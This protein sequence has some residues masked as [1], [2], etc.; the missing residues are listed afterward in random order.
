MCSG[1]IERLQRKP[2]NPIAAISATATG[3]NRPRPSTRFERVPGP[4]AATALNLRGR[5]VR[6]LDRDVLVEQQVHGLLGDQL[7]GEE[8]A[9]LRPEE[10]VDEVDLLVLD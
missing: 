1:P 5:Q 6:Q 2:A 3:K 4:S 8:P 9:R 7:A 10:R